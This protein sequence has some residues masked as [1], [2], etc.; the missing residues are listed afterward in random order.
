MKYLLVVAAFITLT[1]CS[2]KQTSVSQL[3]DDENKVTCTREKVL[4]SSIPQKVCSSKKQRREQE[5][6]AARVLDATSIPSTE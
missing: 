5:R 3:A 4:G 2:S 6:A 1:A